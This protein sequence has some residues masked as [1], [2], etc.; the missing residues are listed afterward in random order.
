[1]DSLP[2]RTLP[3]QQ[4]TGSKDARPDLGRGTLFCPGTWGSRGWPSVTSVHYTHASP[5]LP[6]SP[7][8]I[9]SPAFI[10]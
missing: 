10:S 8:D 3:E 5:L 2:L 1:M 6:E 9:K 7:S 4:W